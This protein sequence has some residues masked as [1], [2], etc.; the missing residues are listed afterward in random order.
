MS[1]ARLVTEANQI[2]SFFRY[3][4][5]EGEAAVADHLRSFWSPAM[6]RAMYALIDQGDEGLDPLAKQ[7]ILRLRAVD[8]AAREK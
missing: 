8:P 3:Q 2:A 7:G 5:G 4:I 1:A 6:R